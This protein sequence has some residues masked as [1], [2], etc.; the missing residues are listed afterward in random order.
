M[1]W[2]CSALQS[3]SLS[4][5]LLFQ[6]TLTSKADLGGK[7]IPLLD[8][9]IKSENGSIAEIEKEVITA[10]SLMGRR[11]RGEAVGSPLGGPGSAW[12]SAGACCGL[13][14]KGGEITSISFIRMVRVALLCVP[15]HWCCWSAAQKREGQ[16]EWISWRSFISPPQAVRRILWLEPIQQESAHNHIANLLGYLLKTRSF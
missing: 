15:A 5:L 6:N 3:I 11:R 13:Y 14:V 7:V 1:E 10:D 4:K 12:R 8:G 9:L 16:L 2:A